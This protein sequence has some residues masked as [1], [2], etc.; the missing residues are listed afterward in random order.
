MF[1]RTERLFLRPGW[2][3]DLDDL[4]GA[5]SDEAIQRT[6]AVWPLPSTRQDAYAYLSRTFD[7]R[8]PQFL[9]YLRS[10]PGARLV[11]GIGLARR[12]GDVE[13]GYWIAAEYLGRGYALEAVRAMVEH[14]RALGHDRLIVKHLAEDD[15]S[16]NVLEA[17]GFHGAAKGGPGSEGRGAPR[18]S[19]GGAGAPRLFVAELARHGGAQ[20]RP[21]MLSA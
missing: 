17:A 14:A 8:L 1:I 11:G 20:L 10:A 5:L 18:T 2:P 16:I 9:M 4:L 7:P 3:E 6:V 12:A 15:A 13:L 19:I 21:E